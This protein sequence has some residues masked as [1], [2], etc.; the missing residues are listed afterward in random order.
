M[1]YKAIPFSQFYYA[2]FVFLTWLLYFIINAGDIHDLGSYAHFGFAFW[3]TLI[4]AICAAVVP[5][6]KFIKK[7][8]YWV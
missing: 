2:G 6:M 8:N 1:K 5:V 7:E 4:G 3:I